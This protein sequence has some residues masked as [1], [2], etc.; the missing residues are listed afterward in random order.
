MFNSV[1]RDI[2]SR[3]LSA[4]RHPCFS[5]A[6]CRCL[7]TLWLSTSH[8]SLEHLRTVFTMSLEKSNLHR[9][10]SDSNRN[11]IRLLPVPHGSGMKT[12]GDFFKTFVVARSLTADGNLLRPASVW[13]EHPYTS[14]FSQKFLCIVMTQWIK[15]FY[16]SNLE[17]ELRSY[18]NEIHWVNF[19][20]DAGFLNVVENRQ[21]FM[22]KDT[23]E[24]SQFQYSGLSWIPASKRWRNITTKRMDQGR[25]W[26]W[27]RD[28]SYNQLV[29]CTVDVELRPELSLS[30]DNTDSWVRI[31][32][33]SN[34][35]AMVFEQ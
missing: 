7:D 17:N 2:G 24:F 3:C 33:G 10:L 21:Y 13:T 25:H 32:H 35:F 16:C 5:S 15:I 19:S 4:S 23:A 1:A 22:T 29:A 20:M 12:G 26:N 8:S 34:K 11:G 30:R 28:G 9:Y 14:L 18:H 6:W 27:T 31:S